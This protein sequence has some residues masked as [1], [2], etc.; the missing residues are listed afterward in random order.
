MPDDGTGKSLIAKIHSHFVQKKT[1]KYVIKV[2][3]KSQLISKCNAYMTATIKAHIA[4]MWHKKLI[5]TSLSCRYVY[6]YNDVQMYQK[7]VISVS[8]GHLKIIM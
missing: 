6:F 3:I 4:D 8:D 5:L 7:F 1:N 2:I